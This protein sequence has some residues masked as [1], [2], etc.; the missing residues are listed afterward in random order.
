LLKK[1]KN[2]DYSTT[3]KFDNVT[4]VFGDVDMPAL[5]NEQDFVTD[6]NVTITEYE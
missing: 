5:T 3:V 1:T 6:L 2:E 4:K